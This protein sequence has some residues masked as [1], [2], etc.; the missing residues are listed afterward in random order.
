MFREIGARERT[1]TSTTLRSLAPEASASASS[2]TRAQVLHVASR[3]A[4]GIHAKRHFLFCPPQEALSTRAASGPN[5]RFFCF[6][7]SA[8]TAESLPPCPSW[9]AVEIQIESAILRLET[10]S[11]PCRPA[12]G[13][14]APRS[15]PTGGHH[16]ITS[17]NG[18]TSLP[19]DRLGDHNR[20]ISGTAAV[21]EPP[22]KPRGRSD[23]PRCSGR[24][25]GQGA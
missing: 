20:H 5:P 13:W 10:R 17:I 3:Q 23:L 4:E 12:P 1:R 18:A 21:A 8:A 24:P 2:A 16:G 22:C 19:A 15:A 7:Q 25:Y 9:Q 14:Q 6:G 11:T